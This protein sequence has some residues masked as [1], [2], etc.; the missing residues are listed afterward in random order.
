VPGQGTR[1]TTDTAVSAGYSNY[2]PLPPVPKN[3]S[4]PVLDRAAG[5]RLSWT[6]QV[7]QESHSSVNR[8]GFSTI[9]LAGDR[10]GIELGFWANE[11]WAQ[12]VGFTRAEAAA[13]GTGQRTDYTLTVLGDTYQLTG[14]GTPLLTGP[15]RDYSPSGT[16]YNLPSYLFLGD[17]TSSA[18]A[19]VTLG[20]V[21]VVSPVPEPSGLLAVGVALAGVIARRRRRKPRPRQNPR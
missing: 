14:N 1:L 19:D 15:L 12:E 9:L 17:D 10:R 18:A 6:A 2:L 11:V 7:H 13:W 21:T 5:F 16:P 3:A 8:A 20:R 4:F